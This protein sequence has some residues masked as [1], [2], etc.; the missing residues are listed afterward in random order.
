MHIGF[1]PAEWNAD[2]LSSGSHW[3]I[4]FCALAVGRIEKSAEWMFFRSIY[5]RL[6]PE[7]A[8]CLAL[9]ECKTQLRLGLPRIRRACSIIGS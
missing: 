4:G 1:V 3:S 7:H 5:L 8:V 9:A 6:S 2:E